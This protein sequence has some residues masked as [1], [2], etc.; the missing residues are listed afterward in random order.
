[1][2]A[3]FD[4]RSADDYVGFI[5][6]WSRTEFFRRL[7]EDVAF[8]YGL[9]PRPMSFIALFDVV[10]QR[11]AVRRRAT[12]WLQKCDPER[13]LQV[14]RAI[15]RT[16]V[17]IINR[18]TISVLSSLRQMNYSRGLKLSLAK[19]LPGIVRAEKMLRLVEKRTAAI[20][21]AYER[22]KE[23]QVCTVRAV[24]THLGLEFQE[25][26]LDAQFL[27]NTSFRGAP[28][29]KLR[30][31]HISA[32]RVASACCSVLPLWLLNLGLRTRYDRE[33]V[34]FVSGTFGDLKDRLAD[35]RDYY[36]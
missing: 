16:K 33:P 2:Q 24:C 13:A 28:A 22:L 17:V 15:Q 14:V 5:E 21:V 7:G 34:R 4:L 9:N 11:Y 18:D 1:M 31:T 23:D 25:S 10:M 36:T 30:S 3:K 27:P 6:V 8:L 32:L 20:S 19:S 35:R 26:M 12:H 29:P